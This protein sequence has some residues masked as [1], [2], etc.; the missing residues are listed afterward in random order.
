MLFRSAYKIK[1]QY[2][3]DIFGGQGFAGRVAKNFYTQAGEKGVPL[4]NIQNR[5]LSAVNNLVRMFEN[6][7]MGTRNTTK[8]RAQG[9]IKNENISELQFPNREEFSNDDEFD[10]AVKDVVYNWLV[11]DI[12]VDAVIESL[13][14]FFNMTADDVETIMAASNLDKADVNDAMKNGSDRLI[15]LLR[16]KVKPRVEKIKYKSLVLR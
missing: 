9:K 4:E 10:A 11:R 15:K 6:G 13:I 5:I 8:G 16:S 7:V 1:T 12:I 3:P 14:P 2:Y